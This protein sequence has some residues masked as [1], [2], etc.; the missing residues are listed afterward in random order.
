MDKALNEL[1]KKNTCLCKENND[2]IDQVITLGR[3]LQDIQD[4]LNKV[5]KLV[6]DSDNQ[7]LIVSVTELVEDLNDK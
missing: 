6:I 5:V 7:Y 1:A 2:M 3:Q 4:I